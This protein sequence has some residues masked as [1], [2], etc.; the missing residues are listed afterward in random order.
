M[1]NLTTLCLAIVASAFSHASYELMLVS[2]PV[3]GVIHRLDPVSGAY[4][5]SFGKGFITDVR[6]VAVNP[7]N[8]LAYV[9]DALQNKVLS[10]EYSS[11]LYRSS[12][13]TAGLVTFTT[14][15]GY[16]SLASNGNLLLGAS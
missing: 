10:F 5:G 14:S 12:F 13:S 4:L 1:K 11:G 9:Y 8:G 15:Y 2:D 3:E 6:S 16:L 7:A